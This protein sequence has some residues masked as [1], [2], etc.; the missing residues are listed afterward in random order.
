MA[1]STRSIPASTAL[2]IEAVDKHQTV[3]LG[4][5]AQGTISYTVSPVHTLQTWVDMAKAIQ[6]MGDHSLCIKDMAG[7]LHLYDSY[8]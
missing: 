2:T 1:V 6:D 7:F 5:H 4:Q 8:E 3:K